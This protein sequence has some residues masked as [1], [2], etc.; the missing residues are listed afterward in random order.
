VQGVS[1]SMG[2]DGSGQSRRG[3][4]RGPGMTAWEWIG[5][6]I[7]GANAWAYLVRPLWRWLRGQG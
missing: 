1:P 3:A 7:I 5:L 2:R 6:V 4:R